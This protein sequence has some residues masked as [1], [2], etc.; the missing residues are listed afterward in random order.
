[1]QSEKKGLSKINSFFKKIKTK[2][3]LLP[4]LLGIFVVGGVIYIDSLSSIAL[5]QDSSAIGT[6][7][8][9]LLD[10]VFRQFAGL[11]VIVQGIITS[12]AILFI[13]MFSFILTNIS[14]ATI[15]PSAIYIMWALLN[16]FVSMFFIIIFIIM[17][18]AQIFNKTEYGYQSLLGPLIVVAILLNFTYTIPFQVSAVGDQLASSFLKPI[19]NSLKD[20]IGSALLMD[21]KLI[22]G[23]NSQSTIELLQG[24]EKQ[25]SSGVSLIKS[26]TPFGIGSI[27]NY[28][29]DK[30][31]QSV[32]INSANEDP[33]VLV[34]RGF[35]FI[36]I[37]LIVSLIFIILSIFLIMRIFIIWL[38]IIA[39]PA[40]AFA[41]IIPAGRKYFNQWLDELI[42]WSFFPAIY[43][44]SLY[45]GLSILN[46][47]SSF[48]TS[49]N[50]LSLGGVGLGLTIADIVFYI[51]GTIFFIASLI[52]ARTIAKGLGI[53]T[54][55]GFSY[56]E[57]KLGLKAI[58]DSAE[59]RDVRGTITNV[60]DKTIGKVPGVAPYYKGFKQG[61][62]QR[63]DNAK[64]RITTR[65]QSGLGRFST[66]QGQLTQERFAATI[67]GRTGLSAN[68]AAA[69]AKE[70][71]EITKKEKTRVQNLIEQTPIA[72]RQS[73]L[74]ELRNSGNT[75]TANAALLIDYEN[76]FKNKEKISIEEYKKAINQLGG[77]KT[78]L[79]K[80][81]S[82][83]ALSNLN[84]EKDLRVQAIKEFTEAD[85]SFDPTTDD[86]KKA[87]ETRL[88]E[89]KQDI[90]LGKDPATSDL[91]ELRR[92]IADS[93]VKNG[94]I[95]AS[96]PDD[97]LKDEAK[98]L[99]TTDSNNKYNNPQ[100]TEGQKDRI[101][102]DKINELKSVERLAV[103]NDISNRL[104][105]IDEKFEFVDKN[106]T[107][108]QIF[109]DEKGDLDSEALIAFAK[110]DVSNGTDVEKAIKRKA[111][112]EIADKGLIKESKNKSSDAVI[113]EYGDLLKGLVE[114][115]DKEAF[116]KN[117]K[118]SKIF[119]SKGSFG[120]NFDKAREAFGDDFIN[121]SISY[122]KKN[123]KILGS[124]GIS[125]TLKYLEN[126]GMGVE[127]KDFEKEVNKL[128]PILLMERSGEITPQNRTQKI[129]DI[130][131]NGDKKFFESKD[132]S[133]Y[134]D[135][136]VKRYLYRVGSGEVVN[137]KL[138]ENLKSS[139]NGLKYIKRG[140]ELKDVD[141]KVMEIEQDIN[142]IY[143]DYTKE[144]GIDFSDNQQPGQDIVN[145][146]L[147]NAKNKLIVQRNTKSRLAEAFRNLGDP[148]SLEKLDK[149]AS[150]I[151]DIN[152]ELEPLMRLQNGDEYEQ[153]FRNRV[154]DKIN[155]KNELE[156]KRKEIIDKDEQ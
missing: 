28:A 95:Q 103:V 30:A 145:R 57:D 140:K 49:N 58:L 96:S 115:D 119:S 12:L 138:F 14:S 34:T 113:K 134:E 67:G 29:L 83:K 40:A 152:K 109:Q 120:N 90:A 105:D 108:K 147:V 46:L 102:Q 9:Y 117:I 153:V 10:E 39:G 91:K 35:V 55:R 156:S 41:Y 26:I 45:F 97:K 133:F 66:Q 71:A 88:N 124:E 22:T 24:Y 126:K 92:K 52:F 86:G 143:T 65:V 77:E 79:G 13:E 60:F 128:N 101:L 16:N 110:K 51:F 62:Q 68:S 19:Q 151:R 31:A 154:Q 3:H 2:L 1:M 129:I 11:V 149:I 43:I 81:F 21:G 78:E 144:F 23:E 64:Q 70:T 48:N 85:P 63:I 82:S 50:P 33:I 44:L 116:K 74:N 127:M 142:N 38:I 84:I 98:N 155:K 114:K 107:L 136:D 18:Y 47:R 53:N 132:S 80:E 25:I 130:L 104:I 72:Q 8:K 131:N 36:I 139:G 93:L 17:A 125:K 15:V 32:G 141:K 100:T 27:S 121:D 4:I 5:A 56:L 54:P 6:G 135:D 148:D 20:T 87:I 37:S 76:K 94:K 69:K 7:A 122:A 42:S 75:A 123:P 61:A 106:I 111:L 146:A 99:L 112:L 89:I 118:P 150:D 137:D 59:K 73:K